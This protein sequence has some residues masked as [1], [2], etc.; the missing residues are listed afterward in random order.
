M[1]ECPS[2]RTTCRPFGSRAIDETAGSRCRLVYAFAIT[3]TFRRV[4]VTRLRTRT[5]R[6]ADLAE[7]RVQLIPE[8]QHGRSDAEGYHGREERVLDQ[9]LAFGVS[10]ERLQQRLHLPDS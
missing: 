6:I 7:F 10:N 9:I 3:A 8:V 5:D 2:S 4:T 1:P